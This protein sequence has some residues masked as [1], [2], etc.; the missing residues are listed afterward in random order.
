[1]AR[2]SHK[3]WARKNKP[4][5]SPKNQSARR[6]PRKYAASCR[7]APQ[8]VTP[9]LR[10]VGKG[11]RGTP[12]PGLLNPDLPRPER[13][14]FRGGKQRR[15]GPLPIRAFRE[16]TTIF[17]NKGGGRKTV[18][19]VS[20]PTQIIPFCQTRSVRFEKHCIPLHRLSRMYQLLKSAAKVGTKGAST[21]RLRFLSMQ[22]G[23]TGP[24]ND[25]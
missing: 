7:P 17:L 9:G 4:G 16:E 2:I 22:T 12:A 14:G 11:D 8:S 13:S 25:L 15:P 1:V 10:A 20:T 18:R 6:G 3:R 19:I 5:P 24:A 23:R 21:Q